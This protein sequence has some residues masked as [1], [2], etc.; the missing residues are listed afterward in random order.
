MVASSRSMA[1]STI[2]VLVRDT[3]KS[4]QRKEGARTGQTH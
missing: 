1:S 3:H 2:F 4:S